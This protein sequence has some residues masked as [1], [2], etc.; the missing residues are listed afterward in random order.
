MGM[1]FKLI[2]SLRYEPHV[3]CKGSFKD[4]Q[5]KCKY[6]T[7]A[8]SLVTGVSILELC[9]IIAIKHITDI[10]EGEPF[11][12]EM[13]FN[14]KIFFVIAVDRQILTKF[15]MP[16]PEVIKLFPCTTQMSTKFQLL[17]KAKILTKK[18][19][20]SISFSDVVFI[21][22]INVKMPTV[23]GIF[24]FMSRIHFMLI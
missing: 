1:W 2:C 22:L 16:G 21:M 11:N 13:V 10:Y 15:Q 17:I 14:G 7:V 18:N 12:F 19:F 3:K 8:C 6:F 5:W 23:F 9:L 20:H 24:T 4:S